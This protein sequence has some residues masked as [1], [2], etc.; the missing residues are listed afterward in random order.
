M[1]LKWPKLYQWAQFFKVLNLKEKILFFLFFLIFISS[2]TFLFFDFYFKNT[3]I[4]PAKNGV[5]VEGVIGVPGLI[6][7]LF[8]QFSEVDSALVEL[9]FSGLLKYNLEG[10]LEPDLAKEFQIL[11]NGKVFEVKL[12]ENLFW[13]DGKPLTVDDIIFT[14]ETI[15]NPQ[16]ASPL[17]PAWL[18]VE[19]EKVSNETVRFKLKESSNIFLE[20]LTLKIIPK[21]I[22]ENI[23]PQNLKIATNLNL[24][25]IGSG[26]YK[27]AG[28]FQNKEGKI[29]SLD[30][31]ENPFY[32]GK[33]PFIPK[34][35]F[36]FFEKKEDL[37]LAFNRGEINAFSFSP[38]EN[39]TLPKKSHLIYFRFPRYFAVFLNQKNSEVLAEKNVRE[40]LNYGT[41]K[42]EIIQKVLFGRGEKIEFPL[43][44]EIYNLK[45]PENLIKFDPEKAK[46]LLK[47]GGFS[48]DEN[49]KMVKIIKKEPV[50]Q[51][52]NDL[53]LGA[54]GK[55]VEEL[56]KCLAKD[57]EIY[58]QGEVTGYFGQ[59][60]KEAVIKFQ[61]KYRQEIL[62]PVGLKKG[63]G[64]V[65]EKTREKLNEICFEKI[66]K[67][68]PLKFTLVTGEEEILK[69][70]AKILKEQ[71]EKLG[72]EIEIKTYDLA[73]LEREILRKK[74]YDALLFGILLKFSP[75]PFP[76]WHS[77]Q[78]GELGLNLANYNNREVDKLLE[79]IRKTQS[80][81][82]KK[83][84]L[85]K[86][87][88]ILISDSP[89]IFLF[90]PY[91]VYLVSS[92]VQGLPKD[93]IF[94]ADSSKRF[95]NIQ[96]WY[97]K[98]KR[99]LK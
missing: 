68:L 66:E 80:E 16:V 10:K 46:E 27:I 84:K 63:T 47:E 21:H 23:P 6:N 91:Y 53:K 51:F 45:S 28:I 57:P 49:G 19:V 2:G 18:G 40:A 44:N 97:L 67:K 35:T 36:R 11:E 22:F 30:L 1:N 72:F 24:T 62:E 58:P 20:N 65:K 89:A 52:K 85:E 39:F 25:P 79:E 61:E 12:K 32:Y 41:N 59:K 87:Q 14:I 13:Q 5:F 99:V 75:D 74:D 90:N 42:D 95:L 50:F 86:F 34:V 81:S 43:F 8:S 94:L 26:V 70:T 98:T 54:E 48:L 55:E 83:E 82:E 33:K 29:V 69:K 3:K 60:T 78:R 92:N 93:N 31:I 38:S 96:D 56:Q 15:Q 17:R 4:I 64:E 71:W 9:I 88:E 77:S 76:F 7:P 37:I 73:T